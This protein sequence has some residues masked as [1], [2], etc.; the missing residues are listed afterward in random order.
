[1]GR[2]GVSAN[3]TSRDVPGHAYHLHYLCA[4]AHCHY[5]HDT[6]TPPWAP[7]TRGTRPA[8]LIQALV[9]LNET[10]PAKLQSACIHHDPCL[11]LSC[12]LEF[13]SCVGVQLSACSETP[14]GNGN[15]GPGNHLA[16]AT[17]TVTSP[18]AVQTKSCSLVVK[19]SGQDVLRREETQQHYAVV[20]FWQSLRSAT[21]S[22]CCPSNLAYRAVRQGHKVRRHLVESCARTFRRLPVTPSGTCKHT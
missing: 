3:R 14:R 5:R 15:D 20:S 8:R 19:N 11:R 10:A 16:E 18:Y 12:C 1:M 4:L 6:H 7:F 21:P 22:P 9:L 2:P 17:V 13:L